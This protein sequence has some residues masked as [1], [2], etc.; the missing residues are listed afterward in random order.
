MTLVLDIIAGCVLVLTASCF[1]AALICAV[2]RIF[3][4]DGDI[5]ERD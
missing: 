1:F 2:I 3:T 4:Y 5:N